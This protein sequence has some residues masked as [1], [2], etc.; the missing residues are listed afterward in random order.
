MLQTRVIYVSFSYLWS[1]KHLLL[2]LTALVLL[3][4]CPSVEG[5]EFRRLTINDGLSDNSIYVVCK[6]SRGFLWIGTHV[7]L[8]RYDGFRFK[9]FFEGP[10]G[11]PDNSIN[12]MFEDA[13]GHLWIHTPRGY[14]YMDLSDERVVQDP[15]PWLAG[16]GITDS[17]EL[18]EA[19]AQGNLWAIHGSILYKVDLRAGKTG[20]WVIDGKPEDIRATDLIF[21][22]QEITICCIDGRIVRVDPV[23]MKAASTESAVVP[24]Q[25]PQDSNYRIFRDSAGLE[26]VYTGSVSWSHNTVTGEWKSLR[27]LIKDVKTDASG[28]VWIATD[29]DGLLVYT[30]GADAEEVLTRPRSSDTAFLGECVQCLYCDNNGVMWLGTYKSG[31]SFIYDGKN[32]FAH[33]DLEDITTIQE[34]NAGYLWFGSDGKGIIRYNP[35]TGKRQDFRMDRNKLLSDIVISS[36]LAPDGSLWFGSFR[37]GLTHFSNGTWTSYHTGSSNLACDDIWDIRCSKDGILYLGTLGAGLQAINLA[38]GESEV[39]HHGNSPLREDHVSSL[40]FGENG[41]LYIGHARGVDVFDPGTKT[42]R[43]IGD[44][45]LADLHVRDIFIDSR[46]LLWIA[47]NK[48]IHA[49]ALSS[50]ETYSVDIRGNST[51][52]H[53][54]SVVEDTLGGL[55]VCSNNLLTRIQVNSRGE[56][57]EFF[58]TS[59]GTNEGVPDVLFNKNAMVSLRNGDIL[60]GS[61]RGFVRIVPKDI[62][63]DQDSTYVIFSGIVLPEGEKDVTPH[64]SLSWEQRSFIIQLASSA[65]GKPG[66]PRFIFS[67]DG[68]QWT[69]TPDG[70]PVVQFAN[71]E[72]GRMK[73]EVAIADAEGNA[74]GPV[75]SL[76]ITVRPPWYRSAPAILLYSLLLLGTLLVLAR[77][78][79]RRREEREEKA[80]SEMKQ[81]FFINISHELRTPLS[82]ILSPLSEAIGKEQ[83]AQVKGNLNIAERNARK[84]LDM[85]N[86]ML[87][88]RG[89][90]MNAQSV[91]FTK[92]NLVDTVCSSVGQFFALKEKGIILT[93]RTSKDRIDML[94]DEDKITKVVTNLLSNAIKYTDEGGRVNVDLFLEGNEA[95]IK[96]ADN[97]KGI[98]DKEKP[99][100][101][102]RFWQGEGSANKGGSGIGLNIV[103]EYVSMHEGRVEVSDTPGGGATFTVTLPARECEASGEGFVKSSLSREDTPAEEGPI[104]SAAKRIN[105]LLVDDSED[106]LDYLSGVLSSDYNVNT[107]TDGEI[108]LEKMETLRPDIVVTDVMMPNMDG[109]QLC[110]RIKANPATTHIPVVMLTA[111]LTDENEKISR[112]CGA[113][114]YFTK[115][116]DIKV[117]QEHIALLVSQTGIDTSGKLKARIE[118]RKVVS[119]DRHFVDKVTAFIE[120]NIVE[121]ELSVEQM[122]DAMGMSRANLYRRLVSATGSTPSEF[123]KL[124]RLR[125]AERL[126]MQSGL[127]VS[128]ICYEVGFTSPRYFSKCYKELYGYLPSEAKRGNTK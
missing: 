123:I 91:H 52:F 82:L 96:V 31:L 40:C 84:L 68:S 126:L 11:I 83:D 115:P 64:M 106:F 103:R 26:I 16:H 55:W 102:D 62:V 29:H 121:S 4:F 78:S 114:D 51:N 61:Q 21:S 73:L 122:A 108:A 72:S 90:M 41:L 97:G 110:Q 95:V 127:S 30:P 113:D 7:G 70:M 101:F 37:G 105:L 43:A 12:D 14:S 9:H 47:S 57:W 66:Q 74:S 128:E 36:A 44:E 24:N 15:S 39:Y 45:Q 22:E 34:D 109:N 99:H 32:T 13:V 93:F 18:L 33:T 65:I 49:Y 120:E 94:Y 88:L 8:N 54:V 117:L 98:P 69:P 85:V 46:D 58:A 104:P 6:D 63:Q 38:T 112:D 118:E 17:I 1:V 75:S 71:A 25:D 42:I 27:L 111:R 48:G 124:I 20:S 53:T 56:G 119:V 50:G 125:H 87:D 3:L 92:A 116:F 5:A 35:E 107:A 100:L 19:D 60:T 2:S 80:I 79:R 81:V 23:T 77:I 10:D 28:R 67:T 89:L 59:Y 76:D 86:Q